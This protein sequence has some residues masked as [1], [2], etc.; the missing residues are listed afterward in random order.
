[1]PEA[2]RI[3]KAKHAATAFSGEG[4][5]KTGGRWNSRGVPVVY[6]SS[7]K[8]LAALESLVHLNPP[9]AF[10]YVA[11]R[12]TFDDAL[13]KIVPTKGLPPN[14]RVEPPPPSTKA[15]G[16]LWVQEA[17]SAILALPSVII[18]GEFN[19]LLN[20]AHPGFKK[21][22]IGKPERFTFDPRLLRII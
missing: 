6:T 12:I 16:D 15:L 17:T 10:K 22:S 19:Y 18:P 14:W 2:W 8:S 3:L 21:I 4:A 5:A 7:T 9:V 20:P 11:I 13:V 1:M